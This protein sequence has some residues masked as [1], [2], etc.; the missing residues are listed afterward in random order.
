MNQIKSMYSLMVIDDDD[1]DQMLYSRVAAA[2]GVVKPLIQF[3]LATEAMRYLRQPDFQPVDVIALDINMP[4]M[5]GYEFLDAATTE[6]GHQFAKAVFVMLTTEISPEEVV[7]AKSFA[8]VKGFAK[9]P[10][11]VE[12]LRSWSIAAAL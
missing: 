6:F 3:S 7:R 2:S 11:T 8:A 1:I 5:N 9:K 4:I 12:T 10:I